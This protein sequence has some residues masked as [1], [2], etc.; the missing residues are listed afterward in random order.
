MGH[1]DEG[2]YKGGREKVFVTIKI[3]SARAF[4]SVFGM[5]IDKESL[6]RYMGCHEI[7]DTRT[8]NVQLH[9]KDLHCHTVVLQASFHLAFADCRNQSTY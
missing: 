6:D 3:R 2:D 8:L 1:W 9:S 5:I 7:N 4:G